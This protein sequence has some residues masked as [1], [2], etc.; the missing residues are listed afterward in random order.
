MR[1]RQ[2]HLHMG[3]LASCSGGGP[4]RG[5]VVRSGGPQFRD[6]P[7]QS[8]QHSSAGPL[9][10]HKWCLSPTWQPIIRIVVGRLIVCLVPRAAEIALSP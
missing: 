9:S 10:S 2:E 4:R 7:R 1:L 5:V 6:P 8:D 3:T